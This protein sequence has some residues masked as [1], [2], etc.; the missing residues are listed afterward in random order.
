MTA[1]ADLAKELAELKERV[2]AL[3][4]ALVAVTAKAN[5]PGLSHVKLDPI[6]GK[7]TTMREILWQAERNAIVEAIAR[8]NGSTTRAAK[9]L[10]IEYRTFSRRIEKHRAGDSVSDLGPINVTPRGPGRPKGS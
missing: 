6:G 2:A 5:S 10:G 4:R 1:N 8:N 9:D 7:P 3:E